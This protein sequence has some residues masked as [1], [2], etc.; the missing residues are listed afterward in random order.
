MNQLQKSVRVQFIY[1]FMTCKWQRSCAGGSASFTVN[2]V[3]LAESTA[4]SLLRSFVDLFISSELCEICSTFARIVAEDVVEIIA[5]AVAEASIELQGTSTPFNPAVDA[6]TS[7]AQ[8]VRNATAE[9]LSGVGCPR[10]ASLIWLAL[11]A[12]EAYSC[13]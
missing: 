11:H 3:G 2:G 7:F 12:A 10:H 4:R 13:A 5:T 1:N 9:T 8:N 6:K